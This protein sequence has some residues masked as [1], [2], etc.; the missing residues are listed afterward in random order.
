MEIRRSK[1]RNEYKKE[2]I[3]NKIKQ[4]QGAKDALDSLC[5]IKPANTEVFGLIASSIKIKIANETD[6]NAMYFC[7]IDC[8]E[9]L[10]FQFDKNH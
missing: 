4:I 6:L 9:S 10:R 5:K 2:A 1:K 7:N 8:G 3:N